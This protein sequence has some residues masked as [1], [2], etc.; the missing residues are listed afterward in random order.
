MTN[1]LMIDRFRFSIPEVARAMLGDEMVDCDHWE[2]RVE[3]GMVIIDVVEP[4]GAARAETAGD[5]TV[6]DAVGVLRDLGDADFAQLMEREIGI[7]KNPPAAE[8]ADQEEQEVEQEDVSK[9]GAVAANF[10]KEVEA[11]VVAEETARD[12]AADGEGDDHGDPDAESDPFWDN[13]SNEEEEGEGSVAET[14]PHRWAKIA[15]IICGERGFWKFI[16]ATDKEEAA[17]KLRQKCGIESRRELDKNP[18]ALAK[19]KDLKASYGAWLDGN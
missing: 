9:T 8:E 13:E 3:G 15:G 19:F 16:F 4:E 7:R 14:D 5:F 1:R 6:D 18:E 12:G 10:A 17:V 11:Q 2:I